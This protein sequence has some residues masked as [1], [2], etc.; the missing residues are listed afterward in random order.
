MN[1]NP[2]PVQ[3]LR[4]ARKDRA[5]TLAE[6]AIA[7]GVLAIFA[8]ASLIAFTQMNR[9]AANARLRTLAM[10]VAQQKVDAIQ[11]AP[12]NLG[13]EPPAVLTKS[14]ASPR[15]MTAGT[16]TEPNLPLDNDSFNS[17]SGLSSA[18][19][20]LDLQ[21]TA[22]RTTVLSYPTTRTVAAVVTVSYKF[23]GRDFTVT[24]STLRAC[25]NI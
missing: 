22:T 19:T 18:Y 2:A 12:W 8:C 20:N 3:F 9:F 21:V 15:A 1:S 24:L 7:A 16:V 6:V 14:T 13:S 17:Q 23:R 5:F 25:D 11:T 10:A 4:C